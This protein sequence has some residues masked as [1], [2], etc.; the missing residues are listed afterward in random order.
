M[1]KV[2][3]LTVNYGAIEAVRGLS[4]EVAAGQ[5]VAIIGA[6]GAGKSTTL[7]AIGGLLN[8][9]TNIFE[10]NVLGFIIAVVAAIILVGI[11]AGTAGRSRGAVR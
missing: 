2:T 8:P 11:Y 3:D 7:N 10:L 1:L 9:S 4:F 5:V 6:N